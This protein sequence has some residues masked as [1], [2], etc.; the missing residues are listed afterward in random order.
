MKNILPLSE[1]NYGRSTDAMRLMNS[2]TE[3]DGSEV[4]L[5]TEEVESIFDYIGGLQEAISGRSQNSYP[6][7]EDAAVKDSTVVHC[8][9]DRP[10][11]PSAAS[12]FSV[13]LKGDPILILALVGPSV[14]MF[15][16]V[17]IKCLHR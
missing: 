3:E 13:C 15:M 9:S 5:S 11:Q 7:R 12:N 2:A 10:D 1:A 6:I 8:V 16:Q 4:T 17:V 14:V